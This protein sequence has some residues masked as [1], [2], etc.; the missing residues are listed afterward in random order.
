MNRAWHLG[1]WLGRTALATAAACFSASATAEILVISQNTLHLGQGSRAVPGYIPAK[2]AYVQALAAWPDNDLPQ[3]TFLQEVMA[4]AREADIRQPGTLIVF[5]QLKGQS[6]YKERYAVIVRNDAEA[7]VAVLCH[8]DTTGLVSAGVVMERPPDGVL[9]RDSSGPTPQLVWL[10]NFHAVFGS[11]AG[12]RRA[13]AAEIGMIISR[14]RARAPAGCPATTPNVVA[15]G[16]W[17]L[18]A[19]DR[20]FTDLGLNAGFARLSVEPTELT[21]LNARGERASAYDHFV[22]DDSLVQVVPANLSAQPV[23]GTSA[24]FLAGVMVPTDLLSFRRRCSDHLP[25]AARI[26]VR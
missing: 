17:N 15:M 4:Q 8:V 11:N 7:D 24:G 5:G 21:S 9:V 25:I 13:E 20:G 12:V 18:P 19:S 23:C 10:L 16:D 14:L 6:S 22:W 26:R 2:N 1:T 3:L